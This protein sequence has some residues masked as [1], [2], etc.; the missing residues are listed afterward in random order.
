MA[1]QG[2]LNDWCQLA[3]DQYSGDAERCWAVEEG[4]TMLHY[5]NL[6]VSMHEDKKNE[7]SNS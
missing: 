2:W 7:E 4:V 6:N 5:A 3:G 1:V